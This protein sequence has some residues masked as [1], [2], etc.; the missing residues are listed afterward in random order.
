MNKYIALLRGIN[1]SGQKKIKMTDLQT[2]FESL[3]FSEVKT[4]IQSGNVIF[5]AKENKKEV[6]ENK[7]TAAIKHN[8]GFPVDVIVV[9]PQEL[10]SLIIN[11]PFV[12][13]KKD[14]DKLHV[15][16]LSNVPLKENLKKLNNSDF[17]PE[18][19]IIDEKYIYLFVPNGYGRAKLNNNFFENKLKVPATT[20]N[21]K[22]VKMLFDLA[23][24]KNLKL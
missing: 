6:N 4:Y 13:K 7:I 20:R 3:S 14:I 8:F 18:K 5:S 16:F 24:Y 2:L 15:V 9:T 21:W 17:L 12:K 23:S 11:N 1:V 10:E 19:F 22:T